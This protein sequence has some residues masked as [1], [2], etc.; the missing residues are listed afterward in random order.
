M[1]WNL[2]IAYT[3]K[4]YVIAYYDSQFWLNGIK[5]LEQRTTDTGWGLLVYIGNMLYAKSFLKILDSR[6]FM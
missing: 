3:F 6:V 4:E 2:D 1:K 5:L